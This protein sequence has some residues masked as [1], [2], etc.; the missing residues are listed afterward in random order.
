LLPDF[1]AYDSQTAPE[2]RSVRHEEA[3]QHGG[4]SRPVRETPNWSAPLQPRMRRKTQP[5]LKR[6]PDR[7]WLNTLTMR[8]IE[9]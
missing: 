4:S 8:A 5:V 2:V 9:T 1:S 6:P 3:L 7:R